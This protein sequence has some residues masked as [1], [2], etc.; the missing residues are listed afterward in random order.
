M[1]KLWHRI[2]STETGTTD[3]DANIEAMEGGTSYGVRKLSATGRD[4]TICCTALCGTNQGQFGPKLQ[5]RRL[6]HSTSGSREWARGNY[7]NIGVDTPGV[8]P[9]RREKNRVTKDHTITYTGCPT[10]T[11]Q[12]EKEKG[13]YSPGI[14]AR[15]G[16][17]L[18]EPHA[19]RKCGKPSDHSFPGRLAPKAEPSETVHSTTHRTA[20]YITVVEPWKRLESV[21][22]AYGGL[23]RRLRETRCKAGRALARLYKG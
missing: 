21:G 6:V 3:K 15:N 2:Q 22:N 13:P 18:A 8:P 23:K 20:V 12:G 17:H 9:Q 11:R 5:T 14:S 10:Y 1:R 4:V 16:I 19:S 7:R